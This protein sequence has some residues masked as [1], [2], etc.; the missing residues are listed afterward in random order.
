MTFLM[1]KAIKIAKHNSKETDELENSAS[2]LAAKCCM[3][4][5]LLYAR[6]KIQDKD[7]FVLIKM[8][9]IFP[10]ILN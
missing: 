8:D 3:N 9:I 4:L 10:T 5:A 6:S 1:L 7:T 2:P